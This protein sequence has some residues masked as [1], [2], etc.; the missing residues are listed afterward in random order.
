MH[1]W[2]VIQ[3]KPHKEDQVG[4]FLTRAAI[5]VFNPKIREV[6]YQRRAAS[7][8]TKPLF[9]SYLFLNI[10]FSIEKNFH[11]IKYTRGVSKI[12]CAEGRAI[13]VQEQIISFLKQQ[14]NENGLIQKKTT[15]LKSGDQVKVR[16]GPLKDLMGILQKPTRDDERV[17]VLLNLLNYKMKATLHW[18]EVEKIRHIY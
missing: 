14:T 10:D 12:L 7:F 13:N 11:N 2:Y 18:T 1:Q 5:E 9:P 8:K 17:I 4:Q 3:T 15:S 16:K 6:Y